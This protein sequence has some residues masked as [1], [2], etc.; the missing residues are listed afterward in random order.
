MK[1]RLLT[2]AALAAFTLNST[3]VAQQGDNLDRALADLNSG[4]VAPTMGGASASG[5]TGVDFSGDARA[6][7]AWSGGGADNNVWATGAWVDTRVRANMNF[8]VNES[9]SAFVQW[10]GTETWGSAASLAENGATGNISQAWF[11]TSNLLSMGADWKMGRSY[12][13]VGSGMVLGSSEWDQR[14][15]TWSGVWISSDAAG[16]AIDA[17]AINGGALANEEMW[18]LSTSLGLGDNGFINA[19]D[20]WYIAGADGS[21]ATWMGASAGGTVAMLDW[22]ADW[23]NHEDGAT[24]D[25]A[26]SVS[27]SMGMGDMSGDF[28]NSISYTMTDADGD[29]TIDAADWNSAG[30]LGGGAWASDLET[31]QIGLCLNLMEGYDVGVNWID[32]G[33]DDNETDITVS[34]ALGGGVDAWVGYGSQ[35]D[36]E[37]GYIQLS[38]NF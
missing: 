18:G 21:E 1:V 20:P 5:S 23:A 35:G 37:V 30:L 4:I 10:T 29:V 7:N 3:S 38:L 22:S 13:T 25:S 31:T 28:I 36:D 33:S 17:F 12:M 24:D 9:S 27:V 32:D 2:L 26:T 8:A 11:S 6:R 34:R 19:I 15:S 16:L 14:P